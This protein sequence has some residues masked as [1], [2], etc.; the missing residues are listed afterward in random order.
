MPD[1]EHSTPT[2]GHADEQPASTTEHADPVAELDARRRRIREEMGG[3]RRIDGIHERGGRTIREHIAAILDDGSFEEVGTF[4]ASER[5]EDRDSTPGDGKIGGFGTIGGRRVVIAGDDRTVKRGSSSPTG[6]RKLRRLVELAMRAGVPYVYLGETGGARIP[7]VLG[8]EGFGKLP[9][10]PYLGRRGREI[11]VVTMIV[12]DSFGGS[13]FVS[14]LSDFR[15]QVRG[16]CLAV[17]SPRVVEV[18][19]GE[20]VGL[21][22][23]GGADVH[24]RVTGQ[25]DDVVDTYEDGYRKLVEFL[26]LV[27][28]RPR[29]EAADPRPRREGSLL[30]DVVPLRRTRAYDVLDVLSRVADDLEEGWLELRPGYGRSLVTGLCRI[31]GQTTGVIASQPKFEAGVLTPATCEKAV[32][33]LVLCDS[34]DLPVLFLQDTPGFMV[35]K[36]VE[37]DRILSKAMTLQQA[38]VLSRVPKVTIVLRKAFGLAFFIL[39]GPHMGTDFVGAWPS[40]QIGFM[41]PDVGANVVYGREL[42]GLDREARTEELDRRADELRGGTDPYDIAAPMNIDEVVAPDDTR[43]V[44][45]T[46]LGSLMEGWHR[47]EQ[48]PSVLRHWP[49][50]Q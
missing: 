16:T 39:G 32:N 49:T 3:R 1:D 28:W 7:D 27:W 5:P 30:G 41:D 43:R 34:Y 40:A 31:E 22:E 10:S 42:S 26:D 8:S 6:S 44:V 25:V 2:T 45:A 4:S 33:L 18:A 11:P 47:R 15:L 23:L 9:A 46:V 19:T 48:E 17:T 38:L 14:A 21:E 50:T 24:A 29:G 20:E 37:H 35:G 36:R 13:S 12:G